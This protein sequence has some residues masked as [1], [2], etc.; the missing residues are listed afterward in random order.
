MNHEDNLKREFIN[1]LE[2]DELLKELNSK[3]N[4][5]R[6]LKNE[7]EKKI[8]EIIKIINFNKRKIRYN[9]QVIILD[10][11][12]NTVGLTN[13]ILKSSLS[14]YFEK[15]DWRHLD[16]TQIISNILEE[17]ENTKECI[18]NTKTSNLRIKRIK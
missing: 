18:S 16:K 17:I 12:K 8:L 7:S 6:K 11:S 15:K 3:S 4:K 13:Q 5:I 1:Y 9:D 2:N 14:N 10:Y